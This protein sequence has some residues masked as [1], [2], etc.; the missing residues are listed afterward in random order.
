M[1][2]LSYFLAHGRFLTIPA[3]TMCSI[4]LASILKD[5]SFDLNEF[6]C[7]FES[8]AFALVDPISNGLFIS[9]A[10]HSWVFTLGNEH[11]REFS[12]GA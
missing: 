4:F 5:Y 10:Q 2:C 1:M 3:L 9:L 6:V 8:I 7:S 11:Q 12:A